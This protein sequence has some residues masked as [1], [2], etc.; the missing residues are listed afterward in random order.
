MSFN[1]IIKT[2][3]MISQI[4]FFLYVGMCFHCMTDRTKFKL[5]FADNLLYFPAQALQSPFTPIV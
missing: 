2:F 3:N 5:L 1:V 4:M